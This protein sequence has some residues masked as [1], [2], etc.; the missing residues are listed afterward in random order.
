MELWILSEAMLALTYETLGKRIYEEGDF[1][2][3]DVFAFVEVDEELC[4]REV[5][6]V[7]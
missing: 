2:L 6:C 7:G 3:A 5:E 4:T 1:V